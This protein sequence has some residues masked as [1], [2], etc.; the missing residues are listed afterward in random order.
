MANRQYE[1]LPVH[2][3]VSVNLPDREALYELYLKDISRGG[4]FVR[5][6]QQFDMRSKVEIIIEVEAAGALVLVGEVVH[7]VTKEQA[8]SWG[9]TPGVGVQF[10]DL[11]EDKRDLLE[12]YLDGIRNRL[13]DELK[14]APFDTALIEQVEKAQRTGDLYGVLGA[15]V[16]ADTIQIQVA[17]ETR[18]EVMSTFLKREGLKDTLKK[19]IISS[20]LALQRAGAV[21]GD[22]RKRAG[23]LFRSKVMDHEELA[24]LVQKIPEARAEL[25]KIWETIHPVEC[26]TA[27][28]MA[29]LADDAAA[30]G[31]LKSALKSVQLA[32]KQHPFLFELRE[33]SADWE[34]SA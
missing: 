29:E 11:D 14:A 15:E 28:R 17:V 25:T 2:Q 4:V 13:D 20:R 16:K 31:D 21:L 1:R 33:K 5:T 22:E 19:R 23:Y 9:G 3:R 30:K 12:S 10:V 7:S 34:R 32:L 8:T 6:D 24:G 27:K 26:A 18:S